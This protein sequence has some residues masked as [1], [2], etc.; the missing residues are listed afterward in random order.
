MK[1]EDYMREAIK[2][3]DIAITEG[4]A[5]FG[6]V[7]V[8]LETGEIIWRDHDRV[9]EYCDPTAHGEVNSIRALCKKNNTLN[10]KNTAFYT[11]SEPC[12]TCLSAMIKAKVPYSYYG[13]E[14]E[15]TASLPIKAKELAKYVKKYPITV[16]SDILA[17]DCLQQRN[18]HTTQ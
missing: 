11:T 16:T 1:H 15:A 5:P 8:D 3:A 4:N 12:A 14:T 18:F 10:L 7:V 2:E 13:A 6:A 17:D 9:K